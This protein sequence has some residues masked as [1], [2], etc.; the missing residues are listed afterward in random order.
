MKQSYRFDIY[1]PLKDNDGLPVEPEKF[2]QTRRELVD[3]FGGLTWIAN[4]GVPRITDFWKGKNRDYQEQNDLFIVYTDRN[5]KHKR[6]FKKYKEKLKNRFQQE[7][8]FIAVEETE[9]L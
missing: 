3:Q 7:E 1:L 4:V 2:Q 8:I 5:E 6:F 9:I